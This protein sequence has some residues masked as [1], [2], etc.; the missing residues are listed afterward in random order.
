[1]L[2]K[3]KEIAGGARDLGSGVIDK[4]RQLG[5]GALEKAEE[6]GSGALEKAKDVGGGAMDKLKS[7]GSGIAGWFGEKADAAREG[8]E[9]VKTWGADKV[10]GLIEK[11]QGHRQVDL[12]RREGHR[13][14]GRGDVPRRQAQG[15]RL[16]R[17]EGSTSSRGGG[18]EGAAPT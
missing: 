9:A 10:G 15:R 16:G 4:A 1:M 13:R 7:L 12:G 8:L 11:R 5:S 14:Q 3:A 6:L 2:D 18:K 17:G